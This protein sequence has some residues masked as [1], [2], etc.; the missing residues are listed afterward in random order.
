[1]LSLRVYYGLLE[2]YCSNKGFRIPKEVIGI[3]STVEVKE[4]DFE[5]RNHY[6][7]SCVEVLP[8]YKS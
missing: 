8:L 6:F 4:L 1:M 5:R 2:D 3:F 7:R